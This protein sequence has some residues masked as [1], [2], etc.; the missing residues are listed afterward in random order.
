MDATIAGHEQATDTLTA[1]C[2]QVRQMN[3][4]LTNEYGPVCM[5]AGEKVC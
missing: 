4:K 1:W 5:L 2:E 3:S